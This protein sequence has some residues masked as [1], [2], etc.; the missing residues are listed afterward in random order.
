MANWFELFLLTFF[1]GLSMFIGALIA[2]I[3]RI[4]SRWLENEIRHTIIAFGGGVILSAVALVL[5]HEGMK[6]LSIWAVTFTFGF[7][8]LFLMFM[9]WFINKHRESVSQLLVMLLD[10]VPEVVALGA[11]YLL[12]KKYAFLLGLLII[13]QNLPEGFNA[14]RELKF[15]DRYKKEKILFSFFIMSFIGP[16]AGLLGYFFL[17]DFPHIIS[18]I[19]LFSSGGILYLVFQDVAPQAKLRRHWAPSLGAVIGFLFGMIGKMIILQIS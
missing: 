10:F 17:S 16:I 15:T 4:G 8:G 18:G 7:G 13:L 14:Y 2:T 1:A 19:M 6:D 5:V 3:K 9:D 11:L 12:A